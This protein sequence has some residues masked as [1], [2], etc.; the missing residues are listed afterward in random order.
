MSTWYDGLR[1]NELLDVNALTELL[2]T[3]RD[4]NDVGE[5]RF[6]TVNGKLD[7]TATKIVIKHRSGA[8]LGEGETMAS[9]ILRNHERRITPKNRG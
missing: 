1:R 8:A 9:R 7:Q 3:G 4:V 2:K 6:R 5:V